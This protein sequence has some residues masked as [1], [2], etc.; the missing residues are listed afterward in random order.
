MANSKSYTG[1]A[2]RVIY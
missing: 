2:V 1:F